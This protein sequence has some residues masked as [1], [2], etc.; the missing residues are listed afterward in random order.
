[1]IEVLVKEKV[2]GEVREIKYEVQRPIGRAGALHMKHVVKLDTGDIEAM[3]DMR[4]EDKIDAVD[5]MFDAFYNWSVEVL[6]LLHIKGDLKY[7]EMPGEHQLS[8][9][10]ALMQATG[11]N[12]QFFQ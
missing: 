2:N 5:S 12:M 7:D 9:F 4:R 10:L 11:E 6:P 8:I 3:E 1:M